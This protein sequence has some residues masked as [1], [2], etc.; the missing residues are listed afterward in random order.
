MTTISDFLFC[1]TGDKPEDKQFLPVRGEPTATGFD[2][3][4]YLPGGSIELLPTQKAMIP[5]GI[6]AMCP[7]GWWLELRPRSSTFAKKHLLSLYGVIDQEFE[8]NIMFACQY[9]P[10]LKPLDAGIIAAAS[11]YPDR[12]VINHGDAIG[13][14]VPVQR[15]EMNVVQ[16]SAAEYAFAC[17]ERNGQRGAGGFGSTG[18]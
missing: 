5:L 1:L 11:G 15:S 17:K 12:L 8:G 4:A 9:M 14:L 7:S 16:V 10:E 2:V 18:A 13:Q 3:R 6:R